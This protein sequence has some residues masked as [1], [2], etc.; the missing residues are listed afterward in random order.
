M[1]TIHR[2]NHQDMPSNSR[3][4]GP[5]PGIIRQSTWLDQ[6][7]TPKVI[8]D[9][10]NKHWYFNHFNTLAQQARDV[11]KE[12]MKTPIGEGL[13]ADVTCRAKEEQSLKEK[14]KMRHEE[15]NYQNA[16]DIWSDIHDLAGVRIILYM[17]SDDQREK[18]K[19]I[20]QS[21]WGEEVEE[22]LH[23]GSRGNE[24]E[25]PGK[26]KSL[27]KKNYKRRHLGYQAIHYRVTMKTLKKEIHKHRAS[28]WKDN[29]NI[30]IQVVS[31]LGHAWAQAGHDVLYKSFAY[32]EPTLQEKRILD[33]VNGIVLSGD[34]LLEEFHEL[35]M[36]RTYTPWT[37][38]NEFGSFLH[39][40]DL[41]QGQKEKDMFGAE[42]LDVVFQYLTL[43]NQHYPLAIRN[44]IKTMGYPDQPQL[45]KILAIFKP[46]FKPTN[47][48]LASVCLIH[49]MMQAGE[50]YVAQDIPE[51]GA[52]ECCI[53]ISALTLLQDCMGEPENAN[54]F[55]RKEFSMTEFEI[56]SFDFVLVSSHR[57]AGLDKGL[58]NFRIYE[59]ENI[60]PEIQ[61]AWKWF[62][63]EAE[64]TDSICGLVFRLAEMGA[65]KSGSIRGVATKDID[66]R[67]LLTRLNIGKLSRTSITSLEE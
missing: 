2:S 42:G 13:E 52:Q 12:I 17:P 36:K 8:D 14:L 25:I 5:P 34:L 22:K 43:T 54:E 64:K 29:D 31:A 3:D 11:I 23:D 40:L 50:Q 66:L 44:A 47:G 9:F 10:I 28:K 37:H 67:T 24:P 38:L 1:P 32:G 63:K 35:V 59:A 39:R 65:T 15:R 55:L 7:E 33:A 30:E 45:E 26:N 53:M 18:V 51:A 58:A 19:T 60:K 20:I 62:K 16:D 48:M 6:A 57:Q 56:A 4:I 27:P 21:I 61:S 46:T 49:H 41:L